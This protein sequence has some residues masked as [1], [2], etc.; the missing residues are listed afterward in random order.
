MNKQKE[1][2]NIASTGNRILKENQLI[3]EK[4]LKYWKLQRS[5]MC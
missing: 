5:V 4:L 1:E 3:H 2:P